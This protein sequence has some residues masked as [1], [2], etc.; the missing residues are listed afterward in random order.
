MWIDCL[1]RNVEAFAI[2]CH[3]TIDLIP[4]E[5]EIFQAVFVC[6]VL[7]LPIAVKPG[8]HLAPGFVG[9]GHL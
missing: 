2:K 8:L 5:P 9:K 1:V 3:A 6:T 7:V 4:I